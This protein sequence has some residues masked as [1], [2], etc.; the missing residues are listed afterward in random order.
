MYTSIANISLQVKPLAESVAVAKGAE[1]LG[2]AIV[3]VVGAGVIYLEMSRQSTKSTKEKAEKANRSHKKEVVRGLIYMAVCIR[4]C[5]SAASRPFL[6]RSCGML[7]LS[8][9]KK[10]YRKLTIALNDWKLCYWA[11]NQ[12]QIHQVQVGTRPS[13]LS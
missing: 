13:P 7:D 6:S 8:S 11:Q 5:R 1:L 10:T 2:E 9:W 4:L 12:R 3:F